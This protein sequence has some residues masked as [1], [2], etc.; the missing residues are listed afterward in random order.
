MGGRIDKREGGGD[1]ICGKCIR[2][3]QVLLGGFTVLRTPY[4][5][6]R[7]LQYIICCYFKLMLL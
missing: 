6:Y 2:K 5:H 3:R 1:D 4:G 7:V